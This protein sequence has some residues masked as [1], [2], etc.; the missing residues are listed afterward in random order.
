MRLIEWCYA[1]RYQKIYRVDKPTNSQP[2]PSISTDAA[3]RKVC[4]STLHKA[5]GFADDLTVISNSVNPH[6]EVLALLVL[7]AIEICFN[8]QPSKCVSLHFNGHHAVSTT[9]FSMSNG[10]TINICDV[11]CTKFLGKTIGYSFSA[12][13]KLASDNMKQEILGYLQLTY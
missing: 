6:Q 3:K 5:K 11:N 12:T 4:S 1:G 13:Q 2:P 10:N 8:F 7:K 9:K